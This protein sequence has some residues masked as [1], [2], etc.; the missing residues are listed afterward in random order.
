M[1]SPIVSIVVPAFNEERNIKRLLLSVA[2]QT[3]RKIETIVVDDGSVDRTVEIAK[4]YADH[5]FARRHAERSLQRNFGASKARGQYLMFLDADM[6]LTPRVVAEC[7][8]AVSKNPNLK[9]LVIPEKTTV[10]GF[11]SSIRR[12]ER[13][14]YEGDSS[15]EVSRFFEKRI[16]GYDPKLTGPEDYDLPYRISKKYALGRI[17]SYLWHHE[18]NIGLTKLLK[19]RFYYASRGA[20]YAQKHPEL[21]IRQGILI[22]RPAYFKHWRKFVCHPLTGITF[23]GVRLLETF[24]A[25]LGFLYAS[26]LGLNRFK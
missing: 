8:E 14:M 13:E 1:K 17:K 18:S 3:Y 24:S 26:F 7:V 20:Y 25:G 16:F 10:T 9:G 21:I 23:L 11:I 2:K 6:E 4:H 19:K 5:V 12:F 15:I 22:F